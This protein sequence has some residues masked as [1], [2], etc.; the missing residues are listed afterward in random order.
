FETLRRYYRRA[1]ARVARTPHFA[2]P[3]EP[4]AVPEIEGIDVKGGIRRVAGNRKLYMDL[5]RRYV[6]G[7]QES[8]ER[9]RTALANGDRALAERIAHTVKGVSGNIGAADAQAAAGNLEASIRQNRVE[10]GTEEVLS[11]FSRVMGAT[12]THIHAAIGE[13]SESRGTTGGK[14]LDPTALM[15]ILQKLTRY[16]EESDSE[17]F[18]YLDSVRN[19]LGASVPLQD[20]VELEAAMKA[21]D[22]SAALA[23]L[24]RLCTSLRRSVHAFK[25]D[26]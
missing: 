8:A 10:A 7:Q 21:Y 9:I 12:L 24:G 25:K 20:F 19:E 6:E 4:A 3:S 17:A 23:T 13:L 22:F 14:K 2:A 18:E 11:Q 26:A 15:E 5:L 1:Q 16:A